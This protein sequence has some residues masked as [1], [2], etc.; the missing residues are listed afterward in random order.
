MDGMV[1]RTAYGFLSMKE[2][3]S[4][5]LSTYMSLSK[6]KQWTTIATGLYKKYAKDYTVKVENHDKSLLLFSPVPGGALFIPTP[7]EREL[8]GLP[9]DCPYTVFVSLFSPIMKPHIVNGIYTIRK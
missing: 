3:L 4:Q 5:L 6:D 2:A 8:M 1:E 7:E 9:S